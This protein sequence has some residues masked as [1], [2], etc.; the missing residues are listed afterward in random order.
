MT[1]YVWDEPHIRRGINV[2]GMRTR[3]LYKEKVEEGNEVLTLLD[4]TEEMENTVLDVLTLR[5]E[6][7]KILRKGLISL[8]F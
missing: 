3:T 5:E 1:K 7:R 8:M 6:F 2:D 4:S